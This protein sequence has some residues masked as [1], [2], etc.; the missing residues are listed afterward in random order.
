[1]TN[2]VEARHGEHPLVVGV[3]C[4]MAGSPQ[5]GL[6]VALVPMVSAGVVPIR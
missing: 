4:V 6:D 1:M 2:A 3:R 5:P